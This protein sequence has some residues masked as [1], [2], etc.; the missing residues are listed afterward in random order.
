MYKV[1]ERIAIDSDRWDW[2]H[3]GKAFAV[4]ISDCIFHIV[5]VACCHG[6]WTPEASNSLD[7]RENDR[8]VPNMIDARLR[9][10]M[11]HMLK[12]SSHQDFQ[13]TEF[14]FAFSQD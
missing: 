7:L 14:L 2:Q 8:F 5:S 11:R 10:D 6:D 12:N 13:A 3:D 4:Q 9:A 1:K